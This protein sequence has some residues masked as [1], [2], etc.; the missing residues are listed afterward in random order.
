MKFVQPGNSSPEKMKTTLQTADVQFPNSSLVFNTLELVPIC[1]NPYDS[2][3]ISI[4]TPSGSVVVWHPDGTVTE[5]TTDGTLKVWFSRPT[6][7]GAVHYSADAGFFKFNSDS[8]VEACWDGCNY[9]WSA[10]THDAEPTPGYR[11]YYCDE[12]EDEYKHPLHRGMCE[13]C[14]NIMYR[15]YYRY[16]Y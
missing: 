14:N 11:V 12:C 13:S 4:K 7:S 6:M 15:D 3:P 10:A 8:S 9:Y 2:Y 1:P 16:G 5:K